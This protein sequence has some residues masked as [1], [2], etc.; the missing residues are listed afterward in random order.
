M[1]RQCQIRKGIDENSDYSDLANILINKIL[2]LKN[3][4]EEIATI[5]ESESVEFNLE[6]GERVF[7]EIAK[8][9]EKDKI[10]YSYSIRIFLLTLSKKELVNFLRFILD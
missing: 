8:I 4:R 7:K 9:Y 3:L 6:E 2:S 5:L 10:N 1:S